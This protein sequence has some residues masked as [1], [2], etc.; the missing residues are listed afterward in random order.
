MEITANPD[1]IKSRPGFLSSFTKY[2]SQLLRLR[3]RNLKRKYLDVINLVVMYINIYYILCLHKYIIIARHCER[4]LGY[5][6]RMLQ[7]RIIQEMHGFQWRKKSSVLQIPLFIWYWFCSL[8]DKGRFRLI[9]S[10]LSCWLHLLLIDNGCDHRGLE[11]FSVVSDI[12]SVK[13]YSSLAYRLLNRAIG[14]FENDNPSPLLL[15]VTIHKYW[16]F[17]VR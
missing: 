16:R 9:V 1:R 2:N 14:P 5:F 13:L 4:R 7:I 12:S 6:Y 15:F 11:S 3:I 17:D 10:L 8:P